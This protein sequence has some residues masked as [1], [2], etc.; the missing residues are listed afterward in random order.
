MIAATELTNKWVA[1]KKCCG[2]LKRKRG[3][4]GASVSAKNWKARNEE[5]LKKERWE[6]Q[7]RWETK[8]RGM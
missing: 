5:E 8:E 7:K 6:N 3:R 1:N 4:E 2:T